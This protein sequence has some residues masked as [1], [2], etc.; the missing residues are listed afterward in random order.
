MTHMTDQ[1]F[2]DEVATLEKELAAGTAAIN[3]ELDSLHKQLDANLAAADKA[4][5]DL[6]EEVEKEEDER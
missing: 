4:F 5:D 2:S 3:A 6:A 1:E